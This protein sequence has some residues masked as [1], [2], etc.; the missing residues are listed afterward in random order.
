MAEVRLPKW[1][2]SMREATV[3]RWHRQAG[4]QVLQG[5]PLADLVTDK[6]DVT[7]ESP[8]GGV[9][10]KILVEADE[11]VPVGTVLAVIE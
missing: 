3:V 6:V 8:Q 5:E 11:T 9:L 4:D 10:S 1:G 2:L 7:L